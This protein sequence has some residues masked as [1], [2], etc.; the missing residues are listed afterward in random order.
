MVLVIPSLVLGWKI[1]YDYTKPSLIVAGIKVDLGNLKMDLKK[2]GT[3][4]FTN[5]FFIAAN[6]NYGMYSISGDTIILDRAEIDNVIHSNKMVLKEKE[7]EYKDGFHKELYLVEL[8]A[9][10]NDI[11]GDYKVVEDNR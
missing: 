1:H 9:K 6:Y 7:V 11:Y 5:T 8:N 2:D 4:V 10:T 3:F